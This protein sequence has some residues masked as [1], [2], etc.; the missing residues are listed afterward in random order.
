MQRTE[1]NDEL[2]NLK[3]SD[4][5]LPPDLDATGA[6]EVVPVHD[7][8]DHEVERDNNPRDRGRS[9]QL[10]VAEESGG[11]VVVAVEEGE[12]LL[13]EEEEAGIQKLEVLGEVVELEKRRHMRQHWVSS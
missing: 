3:T 8:V 2:D 7:D 11:A 4:P 6:L 1:I 13:L 5:L 9:D 12:G 10:S